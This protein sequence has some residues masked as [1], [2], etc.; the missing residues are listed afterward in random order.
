MKD[1]PQPGF[2]VTRRGGLLSKERLIAGDL[3]DLFGIADSSEDDQDRADLETELT[4][5]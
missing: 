1:A 4:G 2:E 5:D 3:H